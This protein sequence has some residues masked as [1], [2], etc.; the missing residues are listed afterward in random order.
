VSQD[1]YGIVVYTLDIYL[2]ACAYLGYEVVNKQADVTFSL[3]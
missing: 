3:A 2:V 1:V